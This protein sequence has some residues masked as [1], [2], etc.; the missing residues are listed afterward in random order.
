[1]ETRKWSKDKVIAEL[2]RVRANG[3]VQDKNLESA[4]RRHFGS[5]RAALEAAGLIRGDRVS[6]YFRWTK[7]SVIE[8]IRKRHADGESID[9][10]HKED[11]ALYAAG[12]TLFGTWNDARRQ[13][14]LPRVPSEFYSPDEVHL[15][16][17]EIYEKGLPL[18]Y[19]SHRD[20]K[21]V[22]SAK[23]HFKGW[24]RAV[25]LLGL[26]S[27]LR[28]EWT[29]Q[30]VIDSIHHR[31]DSGEDLFATHREDKALFGAAISRFGNWSNAL[32]AAGIPRQRRERWT[33]Q[34]I[35]QKL[36]ELAASGYEGPVVRVD[37]NLAHAAARV[38]GTI[39]NAIDVA[40]T[41]TLTNQWSDKR[42]IREILEDFAKGK[43][44]DRRGLGCIK[45]GNAAVHR[46]GSW[47]KAVE[48]A[49]LGDRLTI[50]S[51][52][53]RWT[54]EEL[55]AAIRD[56]HAKGMTSREIARSSSTIERCARRLFGGW[57][58][59]YLA[60]GL[61]PKRR[62]WTREAVLEEVCRRIET[63]QSLIC[64]TPE[65]INL[66]AAASRLVGPWAK[67]I[68]LARIKCKLKNRRRKS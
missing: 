52:S 62:C 38:F 28:R 4:A 67:T 31:R 16:I 29:D 9:S 30:A 2:K 8:A 24:R 22:R 51:P 26:Q 61:E 39:G 11:P 19:S 65:N 15:R 60:A 53:K 3:P 56:S 58:K 63:G 34:R 6:H 5:L 42:V 36:R 57:R 23:K 12:K 46:F 17:I 25:K 14:G 10:I 45:L 33:K 7:E 50:K 48:A 18:I 27:E 13:A 20:P 54:K 21:L 37:F 1:M 40:G 43:P 44:L 41:P 32:A 35:V 55:I 49:G 64:D 68:E 47:Q 66:R 59:A